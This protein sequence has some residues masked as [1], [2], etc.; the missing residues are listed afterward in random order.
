MASKAFEEEGFNEEQKYVPLSTFNTQEIRQLVLLHALW[1]FSKLLDMLHDYIKSKS[2]FHVVKL[3]FFRGDVE[4]SS[5]GLNI[6]IL[7]QG[8][9]NEAE[10]GAQKCL[11]ERS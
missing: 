4:C 8:D 7:E 2:L 9:A 1:T 6:G 5:N 11:G 10:T 3:V